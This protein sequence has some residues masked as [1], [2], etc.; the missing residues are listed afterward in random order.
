[1]EKRVLVG[2]P[3]ELYKAAK[4]HAVE[5]ETTIKQI[6]TEALRRYLGIKE[7]GESK[8]S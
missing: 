4:H 7:G 3:M 5:K 8:K 2:L 1:M 6:V